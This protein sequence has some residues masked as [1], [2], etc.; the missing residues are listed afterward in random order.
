MLCKNITWINWAHLYWQFRIYTHLGVFMRYPKMCIKNRSQLLWIAGM[1]TN[2]NT[3]S[4]ICYMHILNFLDHI[5]CI[6]IPGEMCSALGFF[7]S[8]F[9]SCSLK[10]ITTEFVFFSIQEWN[11]MK[12]K[13][14][15]SNWMFL[16]VFFV[17][18][19]QRLPNHRDSDE[20]SLLLCQ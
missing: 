15:L 17:L 1:H 4:W 11:G 14:L 2:K 10:L 18:M 3:F 8:S 16:H 6:C 12:E 20:V 7:I 9:I 5:Y 19:H 13:E